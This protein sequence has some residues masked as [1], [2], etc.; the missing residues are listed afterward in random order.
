LGSRTMTMMAEMV[1]MVAEREKWVGRAAP[2]GPAQTAEFAEWALG[3]ESGQDPLPDPDPE[4]VRVGRVDE[5]GIGTGTGTGSATIRVAQSQSQR[6]PVQPVQPVQPVR[7]GQA[8]G[9]RGS[10]KGGP[11][12]APGTPAFI[13]LLL[14]LLRTRDYTRRLGSG[15][16]LWTTACLRPTGTSAPITTS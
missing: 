11:D 16:G 10:R 8:E 12:R 15:S 5:V 1:V 13:L 3:P 4:T 2:I 14:L 7:Q 6:P 9:R